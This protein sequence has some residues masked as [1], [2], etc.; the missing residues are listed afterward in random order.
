MNKFNKIHKFLPLG[1]DSNSKRYLHLNFTPS[2]QTTNKTTAIKT[3]A[4]HTKYEFIVSFRTY[5]WKWK[6]D[7]RDN[8]SEESDVQILDAIGMGH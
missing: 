4:N 5:A 3:I 8:G 7:F 2:N 6:K 1:L